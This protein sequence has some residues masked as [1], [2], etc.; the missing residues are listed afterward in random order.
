MRDIEYI[1]KLGF[2]QFLLVDD[3]IVSDPEYMLELVRR[4]KPLKMRW[5]SQCAIQIADYDQLL[6][7]VA[8]SGCYVLSFGLESI[9]KEAMKG[10][11]K[12]WADPNDYLRVIKKVNDAGIEG[13]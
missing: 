11:N 6:K 5:M 2:K 9:Q 10:I 3:N 8:E 4:I 12:D 7:A 13:Q 1:K